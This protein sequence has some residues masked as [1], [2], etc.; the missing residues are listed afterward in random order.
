MTAAGHRQSIFLAFDVITWI[1]LIFLSRYHTVMNSSNLHGPDD[2]LRQ[3]R[4]PDA[5]RFD[6]RIARDGSWFHEGGLISRPALVKL[7]ASVLCREP[8]GSYWLVT[9][10]ERG[11]I[12]VDDVPFIVVAMQCEGEGKQQRI[13]FNTNVEDT[14]LLGPNHP[15]QMRQDEDKGQ[16]GTKKKRWGCSDPYEFIDGRTA[17]FWNK[18]NTA[19]I[20]CAMRARARPLAVVLTTHRLPLPAVSTVFHGMRRSSSR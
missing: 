10:A 7:F 9:P 5:Q 1:Y 19:N 4:Q 12:T 11:A 16:D 3:I 8:D 15:L 20:R 14:F 2:A 13:R 6:I 18:W 17:R